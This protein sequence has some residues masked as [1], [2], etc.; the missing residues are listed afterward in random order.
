MQ[1]KHDFLFEVTDFQAKARLYS[2]LLT[3]N[4]ND[5]LILFSYLEHGLVCL[6]Y[7]NPMVT[8]KCLSFESVLFLIANIEVSK[9]ILVLIIML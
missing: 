2:S 3:M 9:F 1:C 6:Q 8:K 5:L 4:L 7:F